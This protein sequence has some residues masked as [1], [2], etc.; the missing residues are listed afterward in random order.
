MSVTND[1]SY[2]VTQ[3]R[4]NLRFHLE[5]ASNIGP[6]WYVDEDKHAEVFRLASELRTQ[7]A[8]IVEK[9]NVPKIHN[10]LRINPHDVVGLALANAP[11]LQDPKAKRRGRGGGR[12]GG[13]K[14]YTKDKYGRANKAGGQGN[15]GPG[16]DQQ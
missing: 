8:H 15:G 7:G 5:Q 10:K 6:W 13:D 16:T 3:T 4:M 9:K 2:T 14:Q 11:P 12:G 1:K